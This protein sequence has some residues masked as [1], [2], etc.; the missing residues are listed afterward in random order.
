M[1]IFLDPGFLTILNL[2][3]LLLWAGGS[4]YTTDRHGIIRLI[5]LLLAVIAV[6]ADIVF[7]VLKLV[8]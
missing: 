1:G 6:V 3:V 8:H 2:F 4:P 5:V 7:I